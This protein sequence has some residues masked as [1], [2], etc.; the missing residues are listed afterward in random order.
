MNKTSTA[1][2]SLVMIA[3]TLSASIEKS[4][5][6]SNKKN[7][8]ADL[9]ANIN[10]Y[11]EDCSKQP[12]EPVV[13][14]KKVN[15][16]EGLTC[17]KD[18]KCS[19]KGTLAVTGSAQTSL[20]ANIITIGATISSTNLL[21]SAALAANSEA[22]A[23]VANAIKKLKIAEDAVSTTNFSINPIYNSVLDTV[24]NIY[25]QV[26]QGYTVTNSIAVK[27]PSVEQAGQLVDAIVDAGGLIDYINF[28]V[29]PTVLREAQNSLIAEAVKDAYYQAKLVLKGLNYKICGIISISINNDTPL[30]VPQ[31]ALAARAVTSAPVI[32]NNNQSIT[33]RI[34][35]VFE[36]IKTDD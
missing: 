23:A 24:S 27:V 2:L 7:I 11:D 8:E 28:S 16:P 21:A 26:F 32:Y 1:L 18:G 13:C 30:F 35:F 19:D 9:Q 20:P 25:K 10:K 29:D 3:L 36:I 14:E 17:Q 5:K 33:Q 15:I 4:S 12:N 6:K 34:S 31:A 22:S